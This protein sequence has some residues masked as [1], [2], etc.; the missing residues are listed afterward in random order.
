[1]KTTKN[2]Q[3]VE[4][5]TIAHATDDLDKVQVA[6]NRLLPKTLEGR[7]LFTRK[8]LVG[9]YNNPIV[10]FAAKLT[11]PSDVEEFTKFLLGQL[12]NSEIQSIVRNLSL[13]TDDDANLYLRIDKQQAFLGTVRLS[14]R[15]PIRV[16]LKFTRFGGD[17]RAL[18]TKYLESA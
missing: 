9:H 11:D 16:R 14:D 15:D 3:S 10:T 12:P 17:V 4:L 8:Y 5:N 2:I 6:L 7:Q 18:M 1:M 13:H